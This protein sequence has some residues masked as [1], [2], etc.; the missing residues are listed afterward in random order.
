MLTLDRSTHI[1]V[2]AASLA[3]ALAVPWLLRR[4]AVVPLDLT[5]GVHGFLMGIAIGISLIVVASRAPRN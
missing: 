3:I 5:D 1:R 4:F 2:A